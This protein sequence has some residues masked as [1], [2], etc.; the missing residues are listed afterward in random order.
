MVGS[1]VTCLRLILT[2][3]LV[4]S[5]S[6]FLWAQLYTGTVTG[7]VTD[8][9]GAV[10]LGAQVQLMDEEKGFIFKATSDAS[11]SYLFRSVPPGSYKLSVVAPG[12][13]SE[14][15]SGIILAVDHNV[16]VNFSLQ[17]GG[18]DQT[19]EVKGEGTLLDAQ[20]AVNGQ[21][22][23]RKTINDLPLVGRSLSDLA[24]LTPGVT[25]VDTSCPA[26]SQTPGANINGCP[27][28]NFISDGSR[29]GTSDFLIDGVSTS[30]F[31]HNVLWPVYEPS[32]DSVE[33][34]A[35]Q[36]TN[37]SAEYGFTG[38]TITN[39]VTRSGTNDFHGTAYEYIRNKAL[40]ANTYFNNAADIPL[41]ALKLNNFGGTV[42]GPI[43]RNK[44]FFFFDY[45]GT[46]KS[47][48]STQTSGVPDTAE[49]TGDF[50]ELCGLNGGTFDSTGMCSAADG[51]LW[52]PYTGVYDASQGG[53]V[54]SGF[55]P[56]NNMATY[57][58]PGNPNLNGTGYQ[59]PIK[60]GNLID[61]I[62]GQYIL[63]LPLPNY[64]VG[65]SNYNPYTNWVG[66]PVT[67]TTINSYDIKIDQRFTQRDLLSGKYSRSQNTQ[68]PFPCYSNS[69][70]GDPC[71]VGTSLA[72]AHLV[73]INYTH[74]FA[75]TVLLT[76][77]YGLTRGFDWNE[78]PG[79]ESQFKG[80]TPSK[81]LGMPQ[82]MDLSHY[83]GLPQIDFANYSV[84]G[85]EFGG[86][87]GQLGTE[88]FCCIRQGTDNHSLVSSLDWV[89]GNHSF[90]FGWIGMM[91]RY[92][93]FEP[94]TPVGDF[95]YD[96]TSTSEY[97]FSGG[98][99]AI[100]SFLTGVGG[101][102]AYGQY[103]VPFGSSTQSFQYAGFIQ[104][105]WKVT[106]N[107]TLNIGL[108]DELLI[109][110]TERHNRLNELDPTAASP[111]QV[112]G[113]ALTGGE[114]YMT[115]NN[116][117]NYLPN[118]KNFAP[119]FG[120]AYQLH[121][122]LV[123]RGGYGIYFA[124]GNTGASG[125]SY[126]GFQGFDEVTPWLTSY[127]NDH[128]TPWGRFSDPW[129]IVGPNLPVGNSLGLLNNVGFGVNAPLP[130]V[131][132][133]TPYTQSWTLGIQRELPSQMILDVTYIG[134]KGTH[135]LWGGHINYDILGPQIEQYGA[136]QI[137]T[138]QT[139]VPNPFYG[140]IT[141]INSPL[142]SAMVPAY[143]LQLP[144]PQFTGF[145]GDAAPVAFSTY[146]SL[147]M[148]LQKS[149]S[150]GVQF[151]ATYTWSKS[152]DDA[153]SIGSNGELGGVTT[154]QDPNNL[155]GERSLSSFDLPSVLQ[156]S[157]I[158]ELPFGK[159]K[160]MGS[161]ANSV[162]NAVI[163]GW[164]TA[165]LWRFTDGRPEALTLQGGQSLPTY[166]A[167]RP[168]ITGKLNCTNGSWAT[169][170]NNYF[171][172]PQVLTTPAPYALG[173]A[174][175][176][177]GSCRQPGQADTNLSVFKEFPF[178]KLREGAH[179]E[180]R[181]ETYNAFNHPQFAG[182]NTTVNSG[183]FGVITAQANSPREAQGVLRLYW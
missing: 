90:K 14:T 41:P 101:L 165:G 49:R 138:L 38:S 120:F 62:A 105:N 107:L 29:M 94:S 144:H 43:K 27:A 116:R 73:A 87:G 39:I 154:L 65:T 59:L 164:R 123:V 139:Y 167:Q 102:G 53:P 111:L 130:P 57:Q 32:V 118:Y 176:L 137:A 113:L 108:R 168:D 67:I 77:S 97:P 140:I 19:V 158:Y 11:G 54:R 23:D 34:F 75:P 141:N 10:V 128:A 78:G 7:V 30:T 17:V 8:S 45:D 61:P 40:D 5:F 60:P 162:V 178:G 72:S 163:G 26:D 170:L 103:D 124:I 100:A 55:V 173:T 119:R 50:G 96:F 31:V 148:K 93:E 127:N 18:T 82:Y 80:V 98:G 74:T 2:Y 145:S 88:I 160:L 147:Q 117:T 47:T 83:G 22:V 183:S 182:P 106:R 153:S 142:S 64:N 86:S 3:F 70:A 28:N 95:N 52:D 175:R 58:S 85:N 110:Q 4:V 166:G 33:E 151:L 89:K 46:R 24:F 109:P 129:P 133:K 181:L 132:S 66:S 91:H 135:L 157:Y 177:D 44:T 152:I 125:T 131:D 63:L 6:P 179:L 171:S 76:V 71:T 20:D 21:V 174:P 172:N 121:S 146:D 99:D 51:Q 114:L 48:S 37:F 92:N 56:Y 180:L 15:R 69:D 161:S 9:S 143:Q 42:G 36:E 169:K 35:V 136:N 68:P 149:F 25:E 112:P 150:H 12:F 115:P 1:K 159:G 126:P 79:N 134:S 156:L 155:A 84:P 122:N 104:D 16:T 81:T 13:K